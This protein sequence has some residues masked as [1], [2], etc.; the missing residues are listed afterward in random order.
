MIKRG[1]LL[2]LSLFLVNGLFRYWYLGVMQQSQLLQTEQ[3]I[4]GINHGKGLSVVVA[5]NSHAF[6]IQPTIIP[7]TNIA[8]YG[9][10]LEK[11]YYKLKYLTQDKD[12]EI[13]TLLLSFG[14][15]ATNGTGMGMASYSFYW[16]QY[17]SFQEYWGF[18]PDKLEY[19]YQWVK[20][21]AFPY[22][23][24]E[25]DMYDYYFANQQ[26][27]ELQ[28]TRASTELTQ[29]DPA[30]HQ[31]TITDSCLEAQFSEAGMYYFR[32]LLNLLEKENITTY[33]IQFPVTAHY[34][35]K[36]SQCFY[37]QFYFEKIGGI[38][39]QY[40]NT[41]LIDLHNLFELD[42]F[43]DPHHLN[44]GLPR[45]ELTKEIKKRL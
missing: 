7:S 10:T 43:R 9:E 33:F 35:F 20:G 1:L 40:P 24:G 34:Y 39:D 22:V 37:P 16:Q 21:W 45:D 30:I 13:D 11:T 42:A 6:A 2:G 15:N 14:L 29:F 18:A 12:V 5:G 26:T 23:D 32:A 28:K 36:Q 25:F 41:H 4:K 19:C 3:V 38:L 17:F 31:R 44:G 27:I 8:S